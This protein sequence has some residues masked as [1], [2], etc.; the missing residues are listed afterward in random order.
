MAKIYRSHLLLFF[1]LFSVGIHAQDSLKVVSYNLQGM[2]PGTYPE[3]RLPQIINRL[4]ALAPDIIGLQEINQERYGSGMDNQCKVIADSLSSYFGVPYYYYQE[5]THYSWD[6]QY[7]EYIGIITK[8][9]VLET[10]YYQLATGVFPRKVV[11]NLID[12]PLGKINFLST[13]L[14]YNSS[15]VRQ[16]QVQQIMDYI[17]SLN[18]NN[19]TKGTILCGDFNAT[20]GSTEIKKLTETGSSDFYFDTFRE[21]NPSEPG[22]TVPA[23]APTSRIDYIF[24]TSKSHLAIDT[25]YV[26]M[27]TAFNGNT[28]C[29]DHLGVM[30]I[31]QEG[32]PVFIKSATL[33]E[34]LLFTLN[35]AWPNP[36][37]SGT[38]IEFELFRAAKVKLSIHDVTGRELFVLTNE[39][40]PAGKHQFVFIPSETEGEFLICKLQVDA[41]SRYLKL[42]KSD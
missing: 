2:K 30:T 8:L 37:N 35:P 9:P 38:R 36:Y 29:S 31:F 14:T 20:P 17:S 26:V 6:N 39:H 42:V 15:T 3:T 13:H 34:H 11:W 21:N 18:Q 10:G 22:Y 23:N 33:E 41:Y 12:T 4:I 27:N 19:E 24:Q 1:L 25:S 16:Q 32:T 7:N 28:Y 5:F 40:K